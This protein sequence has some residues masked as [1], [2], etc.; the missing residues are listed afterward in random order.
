MN[1]PIKVASYNLHKGLSAFNR[2]FVLH[3]IRQALHALKPDLVFLQEVQ[4]AHQIRS[5]RF[6]K[7]PSY[8]QHEFLAGEL[9]AVYGQ[10]ATYHGGHHGNAILSS[11][12]ILS[13][14]NQDLTLHRF[15]QRGLL[16]CEVRVASFSQSLH[17]FCV[18]LNLLARDRR[19]QLSLLISAIS[20][21]LSP[22]LP[23][24]LAGDF[25]DWKQ[26]A[27][28][29]LYQEL[30][31]TEVFKVHHGACAL[32]FPAR[33][34]FLSLDR[35]YTRGFSVKSAC[36]LTQAPWRGLSDHVPLFAELEW[37]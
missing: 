6:S 22:D 18:H 19:D 24:I 26:E 20:K 32:T 28:S 34:P 29:I 13:W 12:P 9:S 21:R 27:S 14:Y 35:I 2:R 5:R 33:L 36:V 7:W 1:K 8:P 11:F 31:L 3:D 37:I 16:Y 23:L 4:G 10:N 15:E 30:K 17:V 25:N